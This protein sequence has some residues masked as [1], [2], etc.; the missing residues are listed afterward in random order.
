[1]ASTLNN[2]YKN[3]TIFLSGGSGFLGKG[4]PN[5]LNLIEIHLNGN[6]SSYLK[7]VV[8]LCNLDISYFYY[9]M[10]PEA[11]GCKNNQRN[12]FLRQIACE[13]SIVFV[14]DRYVMHRMSNI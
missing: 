7:S 2:F 8:K 3:K 4:A 9:D 10:I 6:I 5:I 12:I 13:I 11:G 14:E 1:M